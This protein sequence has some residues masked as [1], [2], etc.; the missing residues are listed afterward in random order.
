MCFFCI[1]LC[2]F[3]AQS[4]N[5]QFCL[6][7]ILQRSA[8]IR[9]VN[10]IISPGHIGVMSVKM[11]KFYDSWRGGLFVFCLFVLPAC[12][13][14]VFK[15]TSSWSPWPL[16]EKTTV[17][18]Q[19]FQACRAR[20]LWAAVP[21]VLSF[22]GARDDLWSFETQVGV[23]SQCFSD[24][25]RLLLLSVRRNGCLTAAHWLFYIPDELRAAS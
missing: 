8:H 14:Y 17:A 22:R 16:R 6:N 18:A 24:E 20:Q 12:N 2:S 7:V 23:D 19:T 3:K 9:S 21:N 13:Y 1:Y 4:V 5:F 25:T 11:H 10:L 15:C